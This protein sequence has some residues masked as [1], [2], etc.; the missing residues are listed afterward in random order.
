[1]GILVFQIERRELPAS[2]L[3]PGSVEDTQH[4]HNPHHLPPKKARLAVDYEAGTSVSTASTT[5]TAAGAGRPSL[6]PEAVAF[7]SDHSGL[8][9]QL[10]AQA[11]HHAA[12]N[13]VGSQSSMAAAA[14]ATVHP[15][16]AASVSQA[17]KVCSHVQLI[18][19]LHLCLFSS[20]KSPS[21][22]T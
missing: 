4:L 21:Y 17:V 19:H 18:I 10:W 13:G 15:A 16:W 22:V 6:P 12:S 9:Q 11:K 2:P 7:A 8:Y 1:M 14:A 5:S 20:H 3:S